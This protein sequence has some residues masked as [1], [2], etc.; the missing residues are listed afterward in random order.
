[1]LVGW[2]KVKDAD[3]LRK[4]ENDEVLVLIRESRVSITEST[5]FV[6]HR[7]RGGAG[8]GGF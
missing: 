3:G 7:R 8:G 5:L 1:M 2:V 4:G 6:H